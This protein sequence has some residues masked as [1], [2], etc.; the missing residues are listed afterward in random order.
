MA[1]ASTTAMHL[2]ANNSIRTVIW[3]PADA[4]TAQ[5]VDLGQPQGASALCLPIMGFRSF[6]AQLT[7]SIQNAGT[8]DIV[9]F[10]IVAAT[11][12][13][14][15]GVLPVVTH[16]LGTTPTTLQDSICLEC[17]IEQ[18]RETLPTATHVG[19]W[20]D[21]THNDDEAAVTFIRGDA[22]HPRADLTSDYV[23]V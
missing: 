18:I 9:A 21:F 20:A 22:V 10:S 1:V 12:A 2:R 14:G 3:K 5:I 6:F 15:A 8:D 7:L 13:A 19:V 16:A 4:A 11:S 23:Y 17:S